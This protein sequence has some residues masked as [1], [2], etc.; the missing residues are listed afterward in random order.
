MNTRIVLATVAVV[1]TIAGAAY[2]VTRD[3]PNPQPPPPPVEGP[4]GPTAGVPWFVDATAASG[5]TFIN[6]DS[7]TDKHT[8]VETMGAGIGWIDYDNDGWP[9]LF[10]VQNGPL[11]PGKVPT[12]P[13]H[14]CVVRRSRTQRI[15][16][17][18][19]LDRLIRC[20]FPIA[21]VCFV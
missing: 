16:A 8:I 1:G 10:C 5:I 6:F 17:A 2:F 20:G 11:P 13:T 14:K 12:P 4:T 9:D 21:P 7:V 3:R 18:L 15:G 19:Q